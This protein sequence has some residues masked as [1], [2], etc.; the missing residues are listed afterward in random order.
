MSDPYLRSIVTMDA[1]ATRFHACERFHRCEHVASDSP[2]SSDTPSLSRAGKHIV[3]VNPVAIGVDG[4]DKYLRDAKERLRTGETVNTLVSC[5][6]IGLTLYLTNLMLNSWCPCRDIRR[7]PSYG[8]L[9]ICSSLVESFRILSTRVCVA[10]IG[11]VSTIYLRTFLALSGQP[12]LF[13]QRPQ[14][15]ETLISCESKLTKKVTPR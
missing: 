12:I 11:C 10:W 15:A 5:V 6:G 1:A 13:R 3:Y 9:L 7:C 14:T 4:W 2:R 8:H